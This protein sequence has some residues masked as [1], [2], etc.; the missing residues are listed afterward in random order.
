MGGYVRKPEPSSKPKAESENGNNKLKTHNLEHVC[1][2]NNYYLVYN[3]PM[4]SSNGKWVS[5]GDASVSL[6]LKN[7]DIYDFAS[8]IT[9][10]DIRTVKY[11]ISH[12]DI[13][14]VWD[15]ENVSLESTVKI[16]MYIDVLSVYDYDLLEIKVNS[17]CY[18][19]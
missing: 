6:V 13:A 17:K 11:K 19:E 2:F 3:V 12:S 18:L 9:G 14:V 15:A 1:E 16:M 8:D 10:L 5:A 7:D 4:T